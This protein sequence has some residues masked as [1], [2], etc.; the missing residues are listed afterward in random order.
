MG[1]GS[2]SCEGGAE[3]E[4]E[5]E[6]GVVECGGEVE[7]VLGVCAGGY[8]IAVETSREVFGGIVPAG[9]EL[10]DALVGGFVLDA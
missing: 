4:L 9:F 8:D 2:E 1:L 7:G 3:E 5:H 10:G 6:T